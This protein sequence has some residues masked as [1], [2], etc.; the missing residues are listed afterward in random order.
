MGN[1]FNYNGYSGSC[2]ASV[3]DGCLYGRI[4]FINDLITYEGNTIPELQE[5]FKLAVDNYIAHCAKT[6]QQANK[7]YS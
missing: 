3:E 1:E 6:G 7:P 2:V 4:L 5:A